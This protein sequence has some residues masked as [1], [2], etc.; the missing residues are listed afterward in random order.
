MASEY[1]TA[2][3]LR[4]ILKEESVRRPTAR[5]APTAGV[6]LA[7]SAVAGL[8][9]FARGATVG[10]VE[11]PQA[12]LMQGLRMLQGVPSTYRESLADVRRQVEQMTPAERQL[13][14]VGEITGAVTSG[15]GGVGTLPQLLGRSALL[16]GVSGFTSQP[17]MENVGE[18]VL[19]GAAIGGALGSAGY[20][21]Q[22]LI[23]KPVRSAVAKNIGDRLEK[24]LVKGTQL[25][26]DAADIINDTA[27]KYQRNYPN[28]T[29]I[30]IANLLRSDPKTPIDVR[31][32]LNQA[33]EKRE[34]GMKQ[35]STAQQTYAN[36]ENRVPGFEVTEAARRKIRQDFMKDVRET[37]PG[38][39]SDAATYGTAG[40][41]TAAGVGQN[42]L[43]GFAA[44]A[45]LGALQNIRQSR[46]VM[47]AY[48]Y[49]LASLR[50]GMGETAARLG[51]IA[52]TP[53]A[54]RFYSEQRA[55]D[56]ITRYLSGQQ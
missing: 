47:A 8:R 16:G 34:A 17:G 42:V 4:Q 53:E 19:R 49:G 39:I 24:D 28:K 43:G 22:R 29:P 9:G 40:A 30:E 56:A 54:T 52:L 55:Q 6:S 11:Y 25:M 48:E 1:L 13:Y 26:A 10:L 2:D 37:L 21:V 35:F 46:P 50:P 12:A 20:G 14:N 45:G 51:T 44:G 32:T 31:N 7:D 5:V 18:D 15:I 3:E 38:T 27:Q 36:I 33:I 23:Q 41:L